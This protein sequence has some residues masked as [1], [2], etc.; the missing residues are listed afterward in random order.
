MKCYIFKISNKHRALDAIWDATKY[1]SVRELIG[2]VR[3]KDSAWNKAFQAEQ[4]MLD[5][6]DI[7]ADTTYYAPLYLDGLYR[8]GIA[9]QPAPD[10]DDGFDL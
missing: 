5:P 1:K 2:I 9:V 3:Q 8:N 10:A 7:T 4:P 6:H